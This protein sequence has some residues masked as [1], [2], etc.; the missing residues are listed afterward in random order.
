MT[1][2]SLTI[3][4]QNGGYVNPI[5]KKRALRDPYAGWWDQQER[6]NFGEPVHEDNDTLG[7]FSTEPYTHAPPG[8]AF[9]HLSVFISAVLAL[10]YVVAQTYPD[11][12]SAPRE[13]P[14]GLSAEM[15]GP[16]ALGV[17]YFRPSDI[18]V[19]APIADYDHRRPSLQRKS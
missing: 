9:L 12:P 2:L 16:G 18:H 15:G 5:P 8:R 13:F 4:P 10:C 3:P 1:S 19:A 11:R 7:V 14:D 6:R 17:S